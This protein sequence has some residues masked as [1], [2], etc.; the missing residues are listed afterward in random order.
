MKS[1]KKQM[2]LAAMAVSAMTLQPMAAYAEEAAAEGTAEKTAETAELD[3]YTL[4]DV[5]VTAT[6]TEKREVDIPASTEVITADD[7]RAQGAHNAADALR[8]VNGLAYKSMGPLGTAMGTMTNEVTLRGND[9]GTLV[10][11]NGNPVS[12]RGKYNLQEI[13]ADSI[14]R[15]EIVKGGGSVLYGSEA[16]AGVINI[17]TKKDAQNSVTVGFGNY[18]QQKYH[19]NAGTQGFTISYDLNKW[20]S[21]CGLTG[22]DISAKSYAGVVKEYG[23]YLTDF[24]NI[25]NESI[26]LSWK[27]NN[28]LDF[29]YGHYETEYD[30]EKYITSLTAAGA[31]VAKVGDFMNCRDYQTIRDMV[32]VNYH[33]KNWK[34]SL[35]YNTGTVE[36]EGPTYFE[37]SSGTESSPAAKFKKPKK[38]LYDT[39]EKN[40]TYGFDFQRNWNIG[41]KSTLIA[42]L[43]GQHEIYKALATVYTT[44]TSVK[45][46]MRNNWGAFANWEQRFD[47]KNTF[48]FGMRETWTTAAAKDQNYNDFSMAG[49]YLHKFDKDNS[50][51]VNVSQAFIMPTFAQ[52]YPSSDQ[53]APNPDLKPQ[54]GINYELGWKRASGKHLWKAALFHQD[55]KDMISAKWDPNRKEYQYTNADFKNTGIELSCD[56]ESTNGFSY[57]YGITWQNPM[58]NP[59]TEAKS[60]W[61]RK[62]GKFQFTGGVSYKKDK[63]HATLTATYLADRVQ[64]PSAERS[65]RTKPY[66]L[67]SLTVGYA[68][69]EL[70]EI[71]LSIDNV[72]DR[73]DVLTHSSSTY[74]GPGINYM[75]SVTQKF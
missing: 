46:F 23:E 39:R 17:I 75:L 59:N 19:V 31:A 56:I 58:E 12:W 66:L 34:G 67:T 65:Y 42:G 69:T 70:T 64:T 60:Y 53:S 26:S 6:R 45:S 43:S 68:P 48:T 33:D 47:D 8:N 1:K 24:R 57:N 9:A 5:V 51:Y 61:D 55:V 32:Q 28:H 37:T 25:R 72:L 13:P 49:Q 22:G 38:P 50:M 29:L 7:I 41:T 16:M 11:V 15:I 52:M 3:S 40:Q 35:Y 54:K 73:H 2:L 63:W 62:F 74:Y 30:Y 4:D 71:N 21:L 27:A 14:E 36:S 44:G 20:K 18:G 10:L